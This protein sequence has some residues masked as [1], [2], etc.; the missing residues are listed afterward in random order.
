[1][2]ICIVGNSHLAAIKKAVDTGAFKEKGIEIEFFGAHGRNF[3]TLQFKDGI[4]SGPKKISEELLLVSGNKRST[5]D[6]TE[7]DAIVVY[8]GSLYL[9]ELMTSI[10]KLTIHGNRYFSETFLDEGIAGW[11]QAQLAFQIA[12]STSAL[13]LRTLLLPRPIPARRL[14]PEERRG[15]TRRGT[16]EYREAL[17]V[18]VEEIAQSLG[19]EWLMQPRETLTPDLRYTKTEY[20][21]GSTRLVDETRGH[22][23]ADVNHMN[24]S[25]GVLMVDAIIRR[26][27][28]EPSLKRRQA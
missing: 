23:D 13:G 8:G 5:L 18:R 25:F 20:S 19:I 21:T 11:L 6:P 22:G 1:M 27:M 24:A 26:L 3:K 28:D 17:F 4:I 15:R 12:K 2:K 14:S 9:K 10:H 16:T 7:F